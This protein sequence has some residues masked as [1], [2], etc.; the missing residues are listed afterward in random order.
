MNPPALRES[1]RGRGRR[2]VGD[3]RL[4]S[5]LGGESGSGSDED[6][7]E[8]SGDDNDNARRSTGALEQRSFLRQSSFSQSALCNYGYERRR[9]NRR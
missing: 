7:D 1:C 3:E 4:E 5:P 8:S 6:Y 9:V 2:D